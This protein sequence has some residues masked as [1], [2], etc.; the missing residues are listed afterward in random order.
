MPLLLAI[1]QPAAAQISP[2]DT[3]FC[4]NN[5]LLTRV[6]TILGLPSTQ[7]YFAVLDNR[8]HAALRIFLLVAGEMNERA[9]GDLTLIPG[10][11][12]IKLCIQPPGGACRLRGD[13][14]ANMI[15]IRCAP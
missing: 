9:G 5:L 4:G 12:R 8:T 7:T 14:L 10:S 6:E 11:N 1:A 15:R 13:R 2:Q 3:R